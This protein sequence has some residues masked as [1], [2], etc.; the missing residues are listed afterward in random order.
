MEHYGVELDRSSVR[1]VVRKQAERAAGFVD[2]EDRA[3]MDGYGNQRSFPPGKPR[4]IVESDGAMVRTGE[5]APDPEGGVNPVR[6]RPKR[7]RRTQWR[8]VRLSVV[9]TP[10]DGERQY[11]AALGSPQR[12]GEQMFAL[13]LRSGYGENT[14]VH[15]VGDGAPWIARQ[16]EAVFPRQ[17]FLLDRYYLLEHLHEGASALAECAVGFAKACPRLDR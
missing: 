11:A 2:R 17:R 14:Q 10:G 5:L 6:R 8:E 3:A 7:S 12:V 4:L 15:G 1:K 13:A 9:E 16:I